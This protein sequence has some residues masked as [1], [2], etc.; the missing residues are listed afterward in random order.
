MPTLAWWEHWAPIREPA[1]FRGARSKTG[2]EYL[3]SLGLLVSYESLLEGY[4]LL[5]LDLSGDVYAVLPQPMRLIFDRTTAPLT[6]VPD[7]LVLRRTGPSCIVDVKGAQHAT[8]PM[9]RLTFDLTAE[10]AHALGWTFMTV[11]E[12]SE[13][14]Y[15][16][17]K[18]LAGY[19]RPSNPDL[20]R[21][22]S[23]VDRIV[24]ERPGITWTE[25][26]VELP[27]AGVPVYLSAPSIGCA[28]WQGT[29]RVDLDAP[30]TEHTRLYPRGGRLG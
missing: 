14:R 12:P 5:E 27:L 20:A 4:F 10:I 15:A 16:T 8:K 11:H 24:A 30:L 22:A 29:V 1:S 26:E 25:V 13:A 19:R 17:V 6:H 9:N 3:S 21:G 2:W 23:A 18:H 28:I 7:Y